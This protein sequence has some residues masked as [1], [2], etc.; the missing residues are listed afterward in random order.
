MTIN[1][2]QLRSFIGPVWQ[3]ISSLWSGVDFSFSDD[4]PDSAAQ[5]RA[6]QCI[7]EVSQLLEQR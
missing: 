6:G 3:E 1:T 7:T 4:M 5:D 2:T